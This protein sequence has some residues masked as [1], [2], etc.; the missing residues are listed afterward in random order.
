MAPDV[1]EVA[2]VPGSAYS[3]KGRN[4]NLPANLRLPWHY[5]VEAICA[6]C[7]QVVRR[8]KPAPGVTDW[9]HTGRMPGEAKTEGSG[10]DG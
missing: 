5:P 1:A 10:R 3:V 4:A 7:K 6:T 9:P 2:I 8:E